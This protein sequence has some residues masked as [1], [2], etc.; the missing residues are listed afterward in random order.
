MTAPCTTHESTIYEVEAHSP[1]HQNGLMGLARQCSHSGAS[2][3]R[4]WLASRGVTCT[5]ACPHGVLHL[6]TTVSSSSKGIRGALKS[7][8][9]AKRSCFVAGEQ[10][11]GAPASDQ[12][13]TCQTRP[14]PAC[15]IHLSLQLPYLSMSHSAHG[16]GQH[17][18]GSRRRTAHS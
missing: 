11:I 2:L 3:T 4:Q 14:A 10:Y 7:G 16:D 17:G 18:H 6:S 13:P 8:Q 9:R 15:C 5:V 1:F 12:Y